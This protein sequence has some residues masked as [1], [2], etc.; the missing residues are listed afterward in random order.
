MLVRGNDRDAVECLRRELGVSRSTLE[1]WR[2]WWGSLTRSSFVR[3][4][5]CR[6]PPDLDET[7]IPA[8]LLE[9]S[10]GSWADRMRELLLLLRP[11]RGR[12]FPGALEESR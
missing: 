7:A 3:A 5:R 11:M 6:L 10:S 8:S 9:Q 4:I 1:R 2:R 12:A